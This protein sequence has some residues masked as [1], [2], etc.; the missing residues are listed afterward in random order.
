MQGKEN[1]SVFLF[2]SCGRLGWSEIF[3]CFLCSQA[4]L[5]RL[6]IWDPN[7]VASDI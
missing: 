7:S 1:K 6:L 2:V 3:L 4:Q 5:S